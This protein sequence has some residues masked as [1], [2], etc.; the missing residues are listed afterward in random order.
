MKC[1]HCA[2]DLQRM[3]AK[4]VYVW[5]CS[6]CGGGWF[7]VSDL[8]EVIIRKYSLSHLPSPA[9][10]Q[11]SSSDSTTRLI[12][13]VC[14]GSVALISIKSLAGGSIPTEACT[15]CHGRWLSGETM[16]R[17]RERNRPGGLA[18][19]LKHLFAPSRKEQGS[20]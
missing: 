4:N 12:C 8:E 10:E 5:V 1:P 9:Q 6:G 18:T 15:V 13:P 14:Q 2:V 19:F 17:L 7:D 20:S 3:P 11:M 16:S